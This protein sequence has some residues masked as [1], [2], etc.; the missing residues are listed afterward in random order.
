MTGFYGW[1]ETVIPLKRIL[2]SLAVGTISLFIVLISGLTSDFV[3]GETVASRTFSAFCFTSLA[4]FIFLMSCEEYAIF[5]TKREL[6]D[7][8]DNATVAETGEDFDRKEYLHEYE[9]DVVSEPETVESAATFTENNFANNAF[10][11]MNFN[12]FSNQQ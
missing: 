2:I 7:F 12:G 11:P 1:L 3:R 5:K 6:E 9:E 4:S 10:Q 8:V